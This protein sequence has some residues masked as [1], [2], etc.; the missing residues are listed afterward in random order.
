MT[1]T[2]QEMLDAYHA[3]LKQL[4][5][6]DEA[7]LKPER[8]VE[9]KKR[10]DAVQVAEGLSSEG[11]IKDIASLRVEISK[12]LTQISDKLDEEVGKFRKAQEAIRFKQSELE[13]LYGIEKQA[14][15]LAALMEAQNRKQQEFEA[16]TASEK[17]QLAQQIQATRVQWD[18]EKKLREAQIKEWDAAEK[19]RRDREREE[20]DYGFKRE[21]K[22]A[23]EALQDEKSRLEKEIST[24][25]IELEAGLSSREK[26]IA[27]R[28]AEFMELQKR[29]SAFPKELETAVARTIKETS[30]RI[31]QDAK[32]REELL[33]KE[34]EGEKNVLRTRIESLEK[35]EKDQREQ[36]AKLSQQLEKAY[37]KIEDVAV[38]T[39]EGA[40]SAQSFG[41]F[42]ELFA[43]QV[44]R[45][46]PEK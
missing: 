13:E 26:A 41:Q 18:E 14:M 10:K 6:K 1:S 27:E 22:V 39:I 36:V 16:R 42:Q 4:H 20:F 35:S 8:K 33:R 38:K 2:K 17:E 12:I 29:A 45:Q 31:G 28:E 43:E 32:A 23:I 46:G 19:K 30:D 11:A 44:R 5:E 7:E 3:V 40:S 21:Q 34:F 25:R 15:S 37:Q 9:E 24:K